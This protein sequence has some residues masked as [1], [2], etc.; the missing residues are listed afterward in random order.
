MKILRLDTAI[1]GRDVTKLAAIRNGEMLGT[2]ELRYVKQRIAAIRQLYVHPDHRLQ[3]IGRKLVEK[4]CAIA[5]AE[6]GCEALSLL[7]R[8]NNFDALDFYKKLG[9][10]CVYQ[11]DSDWI[12]S[13]PLA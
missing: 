2:I 6:G 5:L 9:F 8:L 1:D 10:A 11:D 13:K 4:C 12:L 3:D 7:V